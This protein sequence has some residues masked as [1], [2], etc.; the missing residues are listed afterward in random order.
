MLKVSTTKALITGRYSVKKS[1][2][3]L[4]GSIVDFSGANSSGQLA[5]FPCDIVVLD[6]TDKFPQVVGRE[7]NAVSLAEQRVKN[8]P[9][10]KRIKTSTP[11]TEDGLI[12]QEFLKGDQRR[13]FVPCPHCGK[14]ILFGWS[15]SFNTFPKLGCEAYVFW[16][17]SAK[18]GKTWNYEEVESS[19]HLLC[20]FCNGKIYDRHKPGM[21]AKGRW[22]PTNKTAGASYRSYHLSSLYVTSPECTLGKL[23]VKFLKEKNSLQGI[24]G[25]VNGDLAEPWVAQDDY[26]R[27]EWVVSK[28]A[29]LGDGNW[30]R[31]LTADYQELE[32]HIW[33]VC[34][35]WEKLSGNSRLIEHGSCN[36]WEQLESIQKRLGVVDTAVGVDCGYDPTGVYEECCRHGQ[37]KTRPYDPKHP[38]KQTRIIVGWHPM[39][40]FGKN[41]G[42]YDKDHNPMLWGYGEARMAHKEYGIQIVEFNSQVLKDIL[43]RM[44]QRKTN[45]KWEIAAE[46]DTDEYRIH[47]MSEVKKARVNFGVTNY[48]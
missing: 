42:W 16:D 4:G 1:E 41:Q 31:F 7:A 15:K 13:Y 5:S 35:A 25:F 11:S 46:W 29:P 37:I 28:D 24:Q 18:I 30:A 44:R 43:K 40:G 21:L 27:T 23:A 12:W 2:Q 26:T 22:V 8:S 17:Q 10:P 14:E 45:E 9:N 33:W 6:E 48:V 39:K 3:K 38:W 47:L 32:P 36:T 19:A 20:P 34:R